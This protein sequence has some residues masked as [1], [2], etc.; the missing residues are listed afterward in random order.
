MT[1]KNSLT[2][3]GIAFVAGAVLAYVWCT[4]PNPENAALIARADSL[5]ARR[6]LD[7]VANAR[8]VALL[9]SA[10]RV[11]ASGLDEGQRHQ[12]RG[13]EIAVSPLPR[14]DST[15]ADSLRFWQDSAAK[16]QEAFL[17]ADSAATA[18]KEAGLLLND[19]LAMAIDS[20]L[21]AQRRYQEALDVTADLSKAL[22][23]ARRCSGACPGI[24][25][26]YG[27]GFDGGPPTGFVGVGIRVNPFSILRVFQ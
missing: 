8:L 10:R 26:G 21:A 6:A 14:P 19:A 5:T 2:I 4:R 13:R 20:S 27:Y 15:L 22:K 23:R 16:A 18:F 11:A 7:S 9:D 1:T 12:G 17:H 3:A 24:V 25:V